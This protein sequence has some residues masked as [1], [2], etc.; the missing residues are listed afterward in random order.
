MRERLIELRER[1]ARLQ[2]QAG[3]E[4]DALAEFVARADVAMR[5]IETGR[6]LVNAA[7]RRPLWIVAGVALLVALRP[8]RTFKLLAGG[9]SL[10]RLYRSARLWWLRLD[11]TLDRRSQH[12]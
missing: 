1:R 4:R 6:S 8:R 5:W 12:A 9:W 2:Q 11:P 10:F 7:V 3:A